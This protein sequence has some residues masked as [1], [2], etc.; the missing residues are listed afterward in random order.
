MQR[1]RLRWFGHVERMEDNN[2]VKRCRV[3]EVEGNR[4]R[5]R[6][7]KTWEQVISADLRNIGVKREIAQDRNVWRK[8]IMMNRLTHAF[9]DKSYTLNDDDD[10]DDDDDESIT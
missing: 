10:D 4:G 2:W 7:K 9:M 5:G 3:M 1:G 8:A 6:P